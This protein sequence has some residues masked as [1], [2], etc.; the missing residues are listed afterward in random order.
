MDRR[1][2]I[3]DRGAHIIV[4]VNRGTLPLY[5]ARGKLIEL[6]TQLRGTD[7][8]EQVKRVL[9]ASMRESVDRGGYR[10]RGS[11]PRHAGLE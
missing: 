10:G 3:H 2:S 6:M 5:D 8:R 4:R 9:S 7:V 1:H 11:S